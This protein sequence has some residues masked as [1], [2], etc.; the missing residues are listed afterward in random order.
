MCMLTTKWG[1]GNARD[2]AVFSVPSAGSYLFLLEVHVEGGWRGEG[3]G[4]VEEEVDSPLAWLGVV[5]WEALRSI[6]GEEELLELVSEGE[7]EGGRE[8]ERE[9]GRE[10]GR[11]ERERAKER[12]ERGKEGEG[13][14]EREGEKRGKE[15]GWDGG[16]EEREINYKCSHSHRQGEHLCR[17]A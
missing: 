15:G 13:G 9:G 5:R 10:G 1:L 16:R 7:R 6:I 14:E 2:L 3:D 12:E 8:G 4:H 17:L 11:R